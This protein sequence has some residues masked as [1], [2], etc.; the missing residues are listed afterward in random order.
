MESLNR[1]G[2]NA[3]GVELLHSEIE[4]KR[5]GLLRD[6]AP[7]ATLFAVI[8]NPTFADFESQL[9]DIHEAASIIGQQIHVLYASS[10]P[11]IEAAF[12]DMQQ[13][14]AG[15]LLVA[16]DPYLNTLS[17]RIATLAARYA[18]P[19]MYETRDSVRAGGLASY[20]VSI[21][22]AYRQVGIYT[23]RILKGDKP[24]DLPVLRPTKFDLV[25]NLKTAKALGLTVPPGMLAITDEVI[26]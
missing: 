20:G 10:E 13:G 12:A 2:G 22:E 24:A 18:V 14:H 26:E 21:A 17:G 9:R 1:P 16:S 3:T 4:S 7:K 6:L 19:A 25:I 8:L 15:A 23:G 11:E 5:L